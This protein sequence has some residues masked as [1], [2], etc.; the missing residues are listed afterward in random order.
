MASRQKERALTSPRTSALPF[1]SVLQWRITDGLD[2]TGLRARVGCSSL[3]NPLRGCDKSFSVP[4]KKR[5]TIRVR[6]KRSEDGPCQIHQR[7][8]RMARGSRP[9]H[10]IS[11]SKDQLAWANHRL[12]TTIFTGWNY[13]Q[14]KAAATLSSSATRRAQSVT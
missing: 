5:T 2:T 1:I 14:R 10:R 8:R 9:L 7:L 13:D 12:T 4:H 3:V 6:T 11:L